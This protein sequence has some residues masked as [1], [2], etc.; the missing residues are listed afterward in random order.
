MINVLPIRTSFIRNCYII[1]R[2]FLPLK[3]QNKHIKT[4]LKTYF[5]YGYSVEGEE[6]GIITNF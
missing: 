4:A 6:E 1:N 3:E 2:R 5:E